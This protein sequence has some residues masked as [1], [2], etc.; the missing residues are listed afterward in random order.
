M[1]KNAATEKRNE[2]F[3]LIENP[4]VIPAGVHKRPIQ[5]PHCESFYVENNRCEDCGKQLQFSALGEPLGPKSFYALKE[6]YLESLVGIIKLF[7]RLESKQSSEAQ[8]YKRQLYKRFELLVLEFGQNQIGD[9][10]NKRLF[11]LELKNIIEELV[12]YEQ[13]GEEIVE[14]MDLKIVNTLSES[15]PNM[16]QELIYHLYEANNNY[17]FKKRNSLQ[18]SLNASKTF[19]IFVIF[20]LASIG[21]SL[22]YAFFFL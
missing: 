7:N 1:N 2:T 20:S 10:K 16:S 13:S 6:R 8:N 14:K 22:F 3:S 15:H 4:L 5:C 18:R 19:Q 21:A 17:E 9:E 12:E 11:Y